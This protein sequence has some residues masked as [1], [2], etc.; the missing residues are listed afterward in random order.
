[1]DRIKNCAEKMEEVFGIAPVGSEGTDPEFMHI[2]QRSIFGEVCYVGSADN[3]FVRRCRNSK[4]TPQ[5]V[6]TSASLRPRYAK[7]CINA[8]R[9]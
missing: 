7:R 9:S 6:C 8:R 4:R 1:M 3:R 2:L 5:P